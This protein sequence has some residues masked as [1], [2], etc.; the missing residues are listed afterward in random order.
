MLAVSAVFA[1]PTGGLSI[2]G[3]GLFKAV[4]AP[5]I[6]A[7]TAL[8]LATETYIILIKFLSMVLVMLFIFI[9]LW[10]MILEV[11][12]YFF[13]SP[14]VF[15]MEFRQQNGQAIGSYVGRGFILLLIK[16][17]LLVLTVIV[18]LSSYAIML[19]AYDLLVDLGATLLTS[20][21]DIV[22]YSNEASTL[23][24]FSAGIM[25]HAVRPFFD[26]IFHLFSVWVGYSIIV[27]GDKAFLD[28]VGYED[29]SAS[30]NDGKELI[31]QVKQKIGAG[32]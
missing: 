4:A 2:I 3:L 32:T 6:K 1:A 18:F 31:D 16:P 11:I 12:K 9:K 7:I 29:R 25:T 30:G 21:N 15:L 14:A 22:D 19:T 8:W 13:S 20:A 5:A 28:A 27:N 24:S 17:L 26:V 23:G 10:Q